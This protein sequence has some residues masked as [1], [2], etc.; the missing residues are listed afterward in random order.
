MVDINEEKAADYLQAI[1]K[2]FNICFGAGTILFISYSI[3]KTN[4]R[5]RL[6]NKNATYLGSFSLKEA[7][8]GTA[9]HITICN[10]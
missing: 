1:L 10:L 8:H 6:H 5:T 2:V 7:S 4:A 3:S 9:H